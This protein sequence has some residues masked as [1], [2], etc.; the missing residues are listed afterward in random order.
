MFNFRQ[1]LSDF[2]HIFREELKTILRDKGVI[3]F[4]FLVPL[5]YP[6]LYT[7]IY[8]NEVVREVPIAVVDIVDQHKAV[9]ICVILMPRPM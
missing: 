3:I 8:T 4:F 1:S 5:G 2:N 6:L 7:F 9:R